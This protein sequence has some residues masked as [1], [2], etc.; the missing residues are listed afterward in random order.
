[1]NHR[2]ERVSGLIMAELGKLILKEIEVEG[3]LATITEANVDGDLLRAVVKVSVYPT[4]KSKEVKK[5]LD[6]KR[7]QLQHL[8]MKQMNIRPMPQIFF[9]I[10]YGQDYAARIEKKLMES[11]DQKTPE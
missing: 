9:E 10:D 4:E 3:A 1:M 2:P 11:G 6:E 5:A 7:G 8:L